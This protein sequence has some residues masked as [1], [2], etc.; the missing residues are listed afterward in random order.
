M[1]LKKSLNTM[2]IFSIAA[3]GMVSSGL[4]ILPAV[5]Y[6][7]AGAGI[8]WAYLIAGFV[9]LPALLSQL[10]LATAIPRAGGTYFFVERILG[11]P[12]G[13][14]AGL[15][16]WLSVA[17][18]SA[19]ALVGIGAFATLLSPGIDPFTVKLIA[20]GACLFFTATNLISTHSSGRLQTLLVL[21]LLLLLF[22]FVAVGYRVIDF[23]QL[24]ALAAPDWNAVFAAAGLVFISYGGLTKIASL[25]EEVQDPRRQLARGAIAAFVII[26]LLYL[27]VILVLLGVLSPGKLS[28]SLTPVSNAAAAIAPGTAFGQTEL[29]LL[30]VAAILAFV[31]TANAGLMSA[32][33]MPLAMSRDNLL[34]GVFS[35]TSTKRG[36]PW[37]S[38]LTTSG[39]MLLIIFLLDIEQLAKVASLFMLLLFLLTNLAVLI[40]RFSRIAH[41]RPTFKSFGFPVTQIIGI[42]VYLFLIF[43]MGTVTI[44]T[45]VV[46]T[47]LALLWYLFYARSKVKRKSAFVHMIEGITAPELKGSG[48]A[49]LEKELLDILLER[50]DIVRDRFDLLVQQAPVLDLERTM[51]RNELFTMLGDE[52]EQQWGYSAAMISDKLNSREEDTSTLIYPGVAV[53]HALPHVIVEGEGIFGVV[54][55][56]NKFGIRWNDS[57]DVVYTAFCLFGSLDQRNFHLRALM[58]IAQILQDPDFHREWHEAR[59]QNDLRSALL[60]TKRHRDKPAEHR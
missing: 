57:G 58:A 39:F 54:L 3:G 34:P 46:F 38:I 28:N 44:L 56:R 59:S 9:M 45:A 60:L 16:N 8:F 12:A 11:T 53:P 24:S 30:S 52:I 10:E 42:A 7:T 47:V 25:A 33:R 15:A 4:F 48:E 17:L 40:I 1:S 6:R 2:D 31:T 36:T 18:K 41:Y 37:V 22:Q 35:R 55:V 21:G 29:I 19:F 13:V 20:A 50:N 49:D 32:S 27:L 14:V 51:D 23:E 5:A 43:K 26:Q